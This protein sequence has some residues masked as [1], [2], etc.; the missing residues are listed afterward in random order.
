MIRSVRSIIWTCVEMNLLFSV[1]VING[2][3][4]RDCCKEKKDEMK[5]KTSDSSPTK[6]VETSFSSFSSTIWLM[7]GLC[8]TPRGRP[9]PPPYERR[10]P[11]TTSFLRKD[12]VMMEWDHTTSLTVVTSREFLSNDRLLLECHPRWCDIVHWQKIEYSPYANE[13][14]SSGVFLHLLEKRRLTFLK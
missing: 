2:V 6:R 1:W 10:S 12:E 8:F 4:V 11:G 3:S 7:F 5:K 14:K 9:L 13:E